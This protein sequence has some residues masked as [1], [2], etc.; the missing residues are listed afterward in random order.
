MKHKHNDLDKRLKIY[1]T[2][3]LLT[4]ALAVGC[5]FLAV[6]ISNYQGFFA[7]SVVSLLLIIVGA[8]LGVYCWRLVYLAYRNQVSW[9]SFA[10]GAFACIVPLIIAHEALTR[11]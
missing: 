4:V 10:L 6:T 1:G 8:L 7:L 11:Q 9:S 2:S 3:S 5:A